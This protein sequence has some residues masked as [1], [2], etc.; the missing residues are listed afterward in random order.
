[1]GCRGRLK[2]TAGTGRLQG[3]A[4]EGAMIWRP[5]A[6]DLS[7]QGNGSAEVAASGILI[8]REF[9]LNKK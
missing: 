9:T 8:W 3:V 7:R 4:G 6:R 5:S 2:L 1:M